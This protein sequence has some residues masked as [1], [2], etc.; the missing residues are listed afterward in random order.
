M[1]NTLTNVLAVVAA[2]ATATACHAQQPV[3][4]AA[5]LAKALAAA[6]GGEVIALAP[7]EYGRVVV[8]ERRFAQPV[9]LRSADPARPARLTFA[10]AKSAG[11]VFDGLDI[12][13]HAGGEPNYAQMNTIAESESVTIR[14]SRVHGSLD[15][16]PGN[17]IVG[18]YVT[19]SADIRIEDSE[20]TEL[21]RAFL[22]EDSD[23]LRVTGNRIHKIR[24]DGGDFA[25]VA[26]VLIEGN[27]YT[28]FRPINDDHP[29]AIQFWTN[30]RPRGSSNVVI[31]NNILLQGPGVGPQGIFIGEETKRLRYSNFL[32]ENNLIYTEDQW[33]ALTVVGCDGLIVRNNTLLSKPGDD[34]Q[35]W[36]RIGRS[37]KV[38][39]ENNFADR[40]VEEESE[41]AQKNN[42]FLDRNP[43]AARR[44]PNL[45]AGRA[46]SVADLTVPGI[47]FDPARLPQA[48]R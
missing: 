31:R 21:F 40:Y 34:K 9:T 33:E 5:A 15:D 12:G 30:Q 18:L 29:D 14:R 35:A 44:I 17:D 38:Q 1:P 42:V 24:S 4:D 20:F 39:L 2:L 28:D 22:F 7:G 11:V 41:V 26:D 32:I 27:H 48:P 13:R 10:I 3:A 25:G 36:I 37:T 8:R 47:G 43:G 46:A 23:R 19:R 16:N 6:R 45:K